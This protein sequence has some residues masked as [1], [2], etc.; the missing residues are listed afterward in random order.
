MGRKSEADQ[1]IDLKEKIELL[2]EKVR[3]QKVLIDLMRSMPGMKNAGVKD[4]IAAVP[5]GVPKKS[6]QSIG[7]RSVARQGNDSGIPTCDG[8]NASQLEGQAQGD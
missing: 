4:D 1:I 5:K 7:R 6:R 8:A 2:T 3:S